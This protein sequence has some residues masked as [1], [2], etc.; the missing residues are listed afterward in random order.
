MRTIPYTDVDITGGFWKEKQELI[1]NVTAK[2]IYDRFSDTYRFKAFDF[3]YKEGMPAEMKPH[4]FW[5]SD[6]AKWIEGA[7]NLIAKK[8][9]PELEKIIDDITDK[10]EAHRDPCGYFNI[11]FQVI[12]PEQRFKRRTDHELYCAGHLMEAACEY[13][14]ATGKDKLLRLMCDYADYIEKCFVIDRTPDFDSPGHEE[15]ELALVKMYETTGEKR[16]LELSKHFIDVRGQK[17]EKTYNWAGN[18]YNQSHLPCREQREAVG[19]AV[20]AVYLYSGMADIARLYEDEELKTA[21]EALFE[22]ITQKRMYVTGGIGS[23]RVGE[24]FTID[25]DLPNITAYTESCATLG[26]ALFARRMELLGVDSKYAAIAEKCIYNG[27]LSS[28]SLDGRS[29]FY[30]NPLEVNP[31]LKT[32][33]GEIHYPQTHRSEVFGCSCCPP[34]ILRFIASIGNFIYTVDDDNEIVYVNQYIESSSSFELGGRKIT[35]SQQTAY[36]ADGKVKI[37]AKGGDFTLAVRVPDWSDEYKGIAADDGYIYYEVSGEEE[38]ELDFRPS[39]KL[40]YCDSRVSGNEGRAAVSCG[41]VVYCMEGADNPSPLRDIRIDRSIAP[42]QGI[43]P[44]LGVPTL[45]F[46][47][48]RRVNDGKL[49]SFGEEK[50]EAFDALFIPYYAFSN[51]DECEMTVWTM[52]R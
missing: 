27:F 22:N 6:V 7:A 45:T 2:A 13:Y 8:R 40:I 21:C 11:Y 32:V 19:H 25:Y 10:I 36:P 49:Y 50:L 28:L 4:I 41:P 31:I 14:R 16:Y 20:R 47:A 24:A 38:I 39:V 51:R 26:L 23:T 30:E 15:I 5:D 12:E 35:V 3:E 52:V 17:E 33:R 37:N 9:E 44:Q 29:F 46:R 48:Y 18:D 1:R 34:N 42:V 43:H